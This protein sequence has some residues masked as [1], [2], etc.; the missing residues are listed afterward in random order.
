MA[1]TDP[2]SKG[3]DPKPKPFDL[4]SRGVYRS[5]PLGTAT[6][7]GLRALDPLLQYEILAKGLGEGILS[8][9]GLAAV[10]IGAASLHAGGALLDRLGLP[11]PR[12]I[13]LGMAVGSAAKQIFWLTYLSR[14]E[15]PVS[16]ALP[17]CFYNTFVDS[18]NSLLAVT[19]ATTAA[20]AS[21]PDVP[22]PFTGRAVSLPIAVGAVM[23]VAG[24]AVETIAE[25]QRKRFKDQ[26]ENKG[27]VCRTGLWSLARH[28][29]YGGY[30]MWR[31]GYA[32]AAG[33][34]PAA[35]VMAAFQSHD[36]ATRA[37]VVMDDYMGSRYSDQWKQ[38]KS[39]VQWVLFPGLY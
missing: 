4:I 30:V 23:Y 36:F 14:E 21:G 17:V 34:W 26:P 16:A 35:L 11:L 9:V 27:K 6:F 29:N 5:N 37:V 31:T 18:A 39:D 13:I 25:I 28:I 2:S 8:A 24:I 10:P 33:S 1:S 20:L 15:F 38:Y 12:A 3:N 22:V 7:I 32:L 19:A